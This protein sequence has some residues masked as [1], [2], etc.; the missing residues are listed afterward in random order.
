M[1]ADTAELHTMDLRQRMADWLMHAKG[2][3]RRAHDY[4][5]A[6]LEYEAAGNLPRYRQYRI[7]AERSWRGAWQALRSAKHLR[8]IVQ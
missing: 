8:D 5:R 7:Y 2:N 6:A 4:K 3:R 1:D